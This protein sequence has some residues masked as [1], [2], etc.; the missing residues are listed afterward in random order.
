MDI[1]YKEKLKG[2]PSSDLMTKIQE[3]LGESLY[4]VN[5]INVK[6]GSFCTSQII[7]HIPP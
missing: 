1:G 5:H 4:F 6:S 2:K 3:Q 7:Y